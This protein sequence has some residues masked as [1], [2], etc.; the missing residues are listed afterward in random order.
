MK[1]NDIQVRDSVWYSLYGSSFLELEKYCKV[2]Q[3][4]K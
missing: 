3:N 2:F 1:F 4:E